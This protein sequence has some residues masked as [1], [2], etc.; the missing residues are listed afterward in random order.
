MLNRRQFHRGCLALATAAAG[1]RRVCSSHDQEPLA[2]RI[3][4]SLRRAAELLTSRQ[5]EDGAWRSSVYG[6]LKEGPSLTSFIAATVR[7]CSGNGCGE[8]LGDNT[9]FNK[10]IDY[11]LRVTTNCATTGQS[12]PMT[13]PVYTAAGA[14]IATQNIWQP[15]VTAARAA[16]LQ[17][18]RGLQLTEPLGWRPV[19][20]AYGGWSYAPL[21]SRP[22]DGHPPS[23]LAVPN[24]S[25]TAFALDA[26]RA[27]G[28]AAS[29]EAI[30]KAKVFVERCQNFSP[31][32]RLS[33]RACEFFGSMHNLLWNWR[34]KNHNILCKHFKNS[35]PRSESRHSP[36][37][38]E[39]RKPPQV[40]GGRNL[41]RP[42]AKIL[43]MPL[44]M[45]SGQAALALA[46]APA[47]QCPAVLLLLPG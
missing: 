44:A 7:Q 6:P 40:R 43:R 11:L 20:V 46:M 37:E 32:C 31:Q 2:E 19:D 8:T 16:W 9:S 34:F 13:Y 33:L 45:A 26:L 23:P 14:L 17:Q 1:H 24:M 5:A 25:A 22:A 27:A 35:Q 38:Q 29:D 3:D 4:H 10:A 39:R 36:K 42:S 28:A 18:L 15:K 47:A 12:E 30:Q 21:P 41:R